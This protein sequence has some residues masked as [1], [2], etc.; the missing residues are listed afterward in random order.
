MTKITNKSHGTRKTERTIGEGGHDYLRITAK[1]NPGLPA[2]GWEYD[3]RLDIHHSF[4]REL[5]I[6]MAFINKAGNQTTR[7]AYLD[8]DGLPIL[9]AFL[10]DQLPKVQADLPDGMHLAA[11][12]VIHQVMKDYFGLMIRQKTTFSDDGHGNKWIAVPTRP[13]QYDS[14]LNELVATAMM[15]HFTP[16]DDDDGSLEAR[17]KN[18][19]ING[20]NDFFPGYIFAWEVQ[21]LDVEQLTRLEG[22]VSHRFPCLPVPDG[23]QFKLVIL[24]TQ[25]QDAA[26]IGA[27]CARLMSNTLRLNGHP[28]GRR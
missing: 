10:E 7:T 18:R 9:I 4:G 24:T 26:T 23:E 14:N 22:I 13:D 6:D 8:D 19:V 27:M 21:E 17:I 20:L 16:Q 25:P 28:I 1:T 15:K 3:T 11:Q 5:W 12:D 2:G